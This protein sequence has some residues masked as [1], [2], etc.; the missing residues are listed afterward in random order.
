MPEERDYRFDGDVHVGGDFVAGDKHAHYP[1]PGP[2]RRRRLFLSYA[3]ADKRRVRRLRSLLFDEGGF[4]P[5]MDIHGLTPADRWREEIEREITTR[6]AFV[7]LLTPA[8]ARSLWC[9]WEFNLA[10]RL[11]KP[12]VPVLLKRVNLRDLP[13][14]L[15]DFQLA[16]LRGGFTRQA[17]MRLVNGINAAEP[18]PAEWCHLLHEVDPEAQT[19]A[20][21]QVSTWARIRHALARLRLTPQGSRTLRQAMLAAAALA[22]VGGLVWGAVQGVRALADWIESRPTPPPVAENTPVPTDAPTTAPTQAPTRTPEPTPLPPGFTPVTRNADWE[23]VIAEHN[24]VP[25]ALVPAGCFQ[26]GSAEGD[27]DEEPVHEV[28]FEEPFWIDVYEV[29]NG[30]YGS[31]GYWSGDNLPREIVSWTDALAHCEARGA[32]LPTEA[33]W[34]YAARGPDGLVYP[35]GNEFVAGNVVYSGNSGSRTWDVG[36]K[37][38]GVSWVGAYDLS[39]NVWE[40]V[41]DWY[42]ADYYETLP[43]GVV[44]PQGP[45][46]GQYRVVRG[47]SWLVSRADARASCR[48]R[49]YPLIRYSVVGFR[50]ALS[51]DSSDF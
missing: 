44:N 50:C 16:D 5:W 26:M 25:M 13:P 30:Q 33:E 51:L 29:T 34:E 31:S 9:R 18:F 14:P 20:P 6:D 3:R 1:T 8:S 39:G 4:E 47:G 15:S 40:W 42:D 10:A 46:S 12:I 49:D 43:D 11:G 28:C 22:L 38:G 35:W 36:S 23:P 48:V 37:P 21:A 19:H 17:M 32:R 24:G 2:A 41:N 7:Y 45:D 27:S